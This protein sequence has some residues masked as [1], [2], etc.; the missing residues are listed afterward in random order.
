MATE[1]GV[2]RDLLHSAYVRG[3]DD[4]SFAARFE[5]GECIH[6]VGP[7]CQGRTP[8]DFAR[9]LWSHRPGEP[10]AALTLN[11]PHW[12]ARGFAEAVALAGRSAGTRAAPARVHG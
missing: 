12:Y 6:Q 9:A 4:G 1:S 11:G 8:A 7:V 10:P 2:Y 5:P 3:W